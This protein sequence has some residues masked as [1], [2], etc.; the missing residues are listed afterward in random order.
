M[1]AANDSLNAVLLLSLILIC[2]IVIVVLSHM[3]A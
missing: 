3:T 1:K 2:L